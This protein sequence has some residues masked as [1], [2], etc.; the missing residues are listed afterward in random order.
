MIADG[1]FFMNAPL[2]NMSVCIFTIKHP[3]LFLMQ[4]LLGNIFLAYIVLS[5]GQTLNVGGF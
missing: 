2:P 3:F 4:L 1:N 5:P